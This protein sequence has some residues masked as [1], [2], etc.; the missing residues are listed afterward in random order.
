[1]RRLSLY[2]QIRVTTLMALI[3]QAQMSCPHTYAEPAPDPLNG[4]EMRKVCTKCGLSER[5]D[6]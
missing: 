5:A 6:G 3:T 4:N 1:M 2:D